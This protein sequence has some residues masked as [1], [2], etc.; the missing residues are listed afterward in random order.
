MHVHKLL[1]FAGRD[2][3][4]CVCEYL[5]YAHVADVDHH[6]EGSRI[7]EV[8]NEDTC[9]VAKDRIGRVLAA[10]AFG[11][12]HDIV[13]EEGGRVDELDDGRGANML[14]ALVAKRAGCKQHDQG[15]E[16]LAA[17]HHDVLGHLGDERDITLEA[18]P[19]QLVDAVHVVSSERRNVVEVD[20]GRC[21]F[22]H[23]HKFRDN[24]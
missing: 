16:S 15:P 21:F 13:M 12:V 19:D 2:R 3:V 24:A 23:L 1:D 14:V 4:G 11:G 18:L 22:G 17:A 8:A 7:Q 20:G 10:A 5:H 9:L 6:L